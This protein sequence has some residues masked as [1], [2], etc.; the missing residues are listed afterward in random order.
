MTAVAAPP[1]SGS[2]EGHAT[3]RGVGHFKVLYL[4]NDSAIA[5][6]RCTLRLPGNLIY[7]LDHLDAGDHESIIRANF[8][9]QGPERDVPIDFVSVNCNQ[10]TG[11]FVFPE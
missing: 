7:N 2:L 11:T 3:W 8:K 4:T 6:T 10:G 9:L 1:S 5:W